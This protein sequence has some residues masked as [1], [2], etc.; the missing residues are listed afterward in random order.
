MEP[1][2]LQGQGQL[3]GAL[4]VPSPAWKGH[5]EV[6]HHKS[7]QVCGPRTPS[8]GKANCPPHS[9]A[10]LALTHKLHQIPEFPALE[11][12]PF[13]SLSGSSPSAGK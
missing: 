8:D 4:P 12:R 7:L 13:I 11:N 3:S 5:P 9:W 2:H 1:S 10:P 6:E